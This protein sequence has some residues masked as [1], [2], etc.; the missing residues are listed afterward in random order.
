[1]MDFIVFSVGNNHYALNIE[2][3]QRIIQAKELTTIPN[4]SELIDGM[5]SYEEKVIKILNFRKLIG[6]ISYEKELQKSFA[7]FKFSCQEWLNELR[8]SLENGSVFTKT[9]N[10][11]KSAL[12]MWLDSFNSYDDRVTAILKELML[13]HKHIHALGGDALELYKTDRDRAK[14]MLNREINEAFKKV[15]TYL[16]IFI[17]ELESVS[18]SLQKLII[19]EKNGITFAIKVDTIEDIAH[20]EESKIMNSNEDYRTGEYLELSGILDIEGVLI[21]VIK[22]IDIPK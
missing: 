21:N 6:L 10:P 9:T 17:S 4:S 20:I 5:M 16:D 3:I 13:S 22:N 11:H 7:I 15:T 14:S 18:N 19:Y 12:G 8:D 2:N 1:M